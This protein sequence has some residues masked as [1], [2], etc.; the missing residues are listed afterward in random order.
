MEMHETICS[1]DIKYQWSDDRRRK[2]SEC[3]IEY[4]TN[5]LTENY[6]EGIL[7][8]LDSNNDKVHY[9]WWKIN[10]L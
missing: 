7:C 8:Q 9:G 3:D 2:L 1:H 4:I 5:L 10:V 6:I